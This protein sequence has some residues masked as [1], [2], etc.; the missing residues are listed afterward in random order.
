MAGRIDEDD[1]AQVRERTR[2]EDVIGAHVTLRGAGSGSMK[3][4]CPFHDEKTPSFTVSPARGFY[5]CFGCGEGG[6]AITFLQRH[7]NISFAEAVQQLADRAGVVLR[8]GDDG[9]AGGG[10]ARIV[11]A[12]RAAQEFYAAWLLDDGEGLPGRRFLDERGF[13]RQDA[14]RF[15]LGFAPRD[16]RA[17]TRHLRGRGF[18]EQELVAAGLARAGGRDFF[19]GRLL[20]PIRDTTDA[21]LGFGGRRVLDDD[22]SPAKYINTPETPI[23]KKSRVLYG[24]DLA[25]RAIGRKNQ[26]VV[27]E[28]YTDVMAAHVAGVDTA[29]AACGTA[30]GQEH[31]K[32]LSRLVGHSERLNGEVVFTFDGDAAGQAAAVKVF[33]WDNAFVA[34]TYVAVEPSG[35]DPCEL[36]QA[37]GDAAV[38]ELVGRRVPLYRFVMANILAGHDLDR[39]DAR[40]AAARE[41]GAL[42]ASVRDAS[43]VDAYLRE[44]AGMLGMDVPQVRSALAGARRSARPEPDPAPE[45]EPATERVAF[46][47]PDP[48]EPRLTSERVALQ[49]MLQRPELFDTSWNQIEADDFRHPSYRAV[50]EAVTASQLTADWPEPVRRGVGEPILERLTMA[51]AA[52]PVPGGVEPTTAHADGW[53]A[54]LRL[55]RLSVAIEELTSK[56]QRVNPVEAPEEHLALFADLVEL[57]RERKRLLDLQFGQ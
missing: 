17:L 38:R 47:W 20:W 4:L 56:A 29:V 7:L 37:A 26:A 10:R 54:R 13:S 18:S 23:Y 31:A 45:P 51:L 3:G 43:M 5:Y 16:G 35:M 1:I 15:G 28:G 19:V 36:R 12:N 6:D 8:R 9:P 55:R 27:V 44:L 39:A 34:Q 11:E 2:I 21:V 40:L 42:L 33:G 41:A 30:F 50:F 25:R 22:R 32:M 57:Q 49:L 48:M 46:P 24:L 14:E 53:A 52:E